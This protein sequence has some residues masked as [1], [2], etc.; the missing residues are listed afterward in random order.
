[1]GSKDESPSRSTAWSITNEWML[2]YDVWRWLMANLM[3]SY[4]VSWR[5]IVFHDVKWYLMASYGVSWHHIISHDVQWYFWRFVVSHDVKW[6]LMTS[7]GISW[8]HMVSYDVCGILWRLMLSYDVLWYLVTSLVSH[9]VLWYIMTYYDISYN[10]GVMWPILF[11]KIAHR[12][13]ERMQLMKWIGCIISM[14]CKAVR[15]DFIKY[16]KIGISTRQFKS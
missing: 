11:L 5:H 3:P 14:L 1:M 8:R 4:G 16:T 15:Q 9:G 2:F 6:Y 12:E 7:Y 13:G 10:F